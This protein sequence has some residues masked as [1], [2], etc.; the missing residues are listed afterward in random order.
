[1]SLFLKPLYTQHFRDAVKSK[2]PR[3][4]KAIIFSS[5]PDRRLCPFFTICG[6]NSP[7]R[8][9]GMVISA[10]PNG[11]YTESQILLSQVE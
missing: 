11:G 9:R 10:T 8:S 2:I 6:S 4:Y 3:A 1:M 7:C 5:I